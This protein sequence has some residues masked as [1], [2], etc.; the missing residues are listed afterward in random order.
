MCPFILVDANLLRF[1]ATGIEE[2]RQRKVW[3]RYY[4]GDRLLPHGRQ[5]ELQVP[6]ETTPRQ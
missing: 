1:D 3:G 4:V 2:H 5:G 6:V